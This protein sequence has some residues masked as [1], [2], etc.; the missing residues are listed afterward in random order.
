MP[1]SICGKI[2]VETCLHFF[3]IPVLNPDGVAYREIAFTQVGG[4]VCND[5]H[6]LLARTLEHKGMPTRSIEPLGGET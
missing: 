5:N 6:H 1:C 3:C 2:V 4:S